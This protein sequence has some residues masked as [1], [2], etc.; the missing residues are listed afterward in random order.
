MLSEEDLSDLPKIAPLAA[1]ALPENCGYKSSILKK[2]KKKKKGRDGMFNS[3][4]FLQT[5][6]I[7]S[8][9]IQKFSFH[10]QVN[11]TEQKQSI[12]SIVPRWAREFVDI[13]ENIQEVDTNGKGYGGCKL[14][15]VRFNSEQQVEEH[16]AGKRHIENQVTIQIVIC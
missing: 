9:L 10:T 2:R 8:I 11:P 4:F 1:N 15:G 16:F 5:T 14:C 7:K 13:E 12:Q 3:R 6:Q